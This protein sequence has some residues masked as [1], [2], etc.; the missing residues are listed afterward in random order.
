MAKRKNATT[1]TVQH[2]STSEAVKTRPRKRTHNTTH[3][4]AEAPVKVEDSE[5][6]SLPAISFQPL[7][8]VHLDELAKIWD[9][10]R[11]IPTVDSRRAWAMARNIKPDLVH[12][13]FARRKQIAKK[14]RQRIPEGTYKLRVGTPPIIKDE[15]PPAPPVLE[16][17][18]SSLIKLKTEDIDSALDMCTSDTL[19]A[20]SPLPRGLKRKPD[21]MST[22]A[23]PLAKP[24]SPLPPSSPPIPSSPPPSVPSLRL[25]SPTPS[26]PDT[27]HQ[28]QTWCT[29]G[30][31]QA[32]TSAPSFICALCITG[33]YNVPLA[34][35]ARCH[36]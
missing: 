21:G 32:S 6:V 17:P 16:E 4:A 22:T 24:R 13:W 34:K 28:N 8:P 23:T 5:A 27:L 15:T 31:A 30:R 9:N 18:P 19:V 25:R 14:A 2:T 36:C 12:R 35:H 10:D 33:S 1:E 7:A 29:Q 11:R 26:V 20:S 3:H